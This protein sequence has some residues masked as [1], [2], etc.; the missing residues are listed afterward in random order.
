MDCC[1]PA[2]LRARRMPASSVNRPASVQGR[3]THYDES[4][5]CL[6]SVTHRSKVELNEFGC[7]NGSGSVVMVFV[8]VRK[9]GR[10]PGRDEA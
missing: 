6:I 8:T 7:G 4:G 2:L 10:G 9:R 1:L 5:R 3:A